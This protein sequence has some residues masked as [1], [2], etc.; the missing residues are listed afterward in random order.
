MRIRHKYSLILTDWNPLPVDDSGFR[1]VD[2]QDTQALAELILC[3]Y[4]GTVDDENEGPQE[5]LNVIQGFFE[6]AYV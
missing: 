1:Q 6:G 5:A 4:K 3:S 2:S